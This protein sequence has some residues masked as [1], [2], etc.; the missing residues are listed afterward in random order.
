MSSRPPVTPGSQLVHIP[1]AAGDNS[2]RSKAQQEF[3]R[4]SQRIA[5]REQ[6]VAAFR[7]AANELRQQV[8]HEYRSLQAAHNDLRAQLVRLLDEACELR[9]LTKAE[10]AK[11]AY[12]IGEA[13]SD[14][15][16]KGHPDLQPVISKYASPPSAEETQAAHHQTAEQLREYFSQRF[17]IE[18]AADADVSTPEKLRAYVQQLLA[19]RRAAQHAAEQARA[20][21]RAQRKKTPKQQA[22]AEQKQAEQASSTKA[23]RTLYL[24]LVKHLHP[25][26]EPD[27]AERLR[28]TELLKRVT[29]AYEASELLTLLRLQLELNRLDQ[30]HLETLADNQLRYYNQLLREQAGELDQ[31]LHREQSELAAFTGLPLAHTATPATMHHGYQRQKKQLE[32]K[33]TELTAELEAMEQDPAALK[34]FLRSFKLPA[35]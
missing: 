8:Q 13:C 27:E 31:L 15:P 24:D 19:E 9:L 25:D 34:A 1:V 5:G 20:A 33:V 23:V 28:K 30:Q 21:R 7:E 2:L 22:A 6:E 12:L 16:A 4:L 35:Y 14:L 10:R 17:G 26:R 18:F 3:N 11:A 32:A 29:T